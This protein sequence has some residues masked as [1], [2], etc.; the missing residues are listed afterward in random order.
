VG[1][2][3]A[4]STRVVKTWRAVKGGGF[5]AGRNQGSGSERHH[6]EVEGAVGEPDGAEE[7]EDDGDRDA[8]AAFVAAPAEPRDERVGGGDEGELAEFHA[9]VEGDQA[10]HEAGGAV[11]W[12]DDFAGGKVGEF[13]TEFA[14]AVVTLTTECAVTTTRRRMTPLSAMGPGAAVPSTWSLS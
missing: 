13:E 5:L 11:K 1:R 6:A 7:G 9:A 2:A 14:R 12:L 10:T 8:A 3:T 4:K